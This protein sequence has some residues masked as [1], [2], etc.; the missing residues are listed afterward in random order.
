MKVNY[1]FLFVLIFT[2]F[3]LTAWAHDVDYDALVN[4]L[5][6]SD[7]YSKSASSDYALASLA[8]QD[9]LVAWLPN[10][11][12]GSTV[13]P[14]QSSGAL[15]Q[16]SQSN[17][18]D[19]SLSHSSMFN[20]TL[21][22]N[23]PWGGAV[24]FSEENTVLSSSVGVSDFLFQYQ[25]SFGLT[26]HQPLVPP[27]DGWSA[28]NQSTGALEQIA[29]SHWVMANGARVSDLL[30][31]LGNARI[32]SDE[33]QI[34]DKISDL[35]RIQKLADNELLA[36]GRLR[37]LDLRDHDSSRRQELAEKQ[38]VVSDLLEVRSKLAEAGLDDSWISSD[39]EDWIL[40]WDSQITNRTSSNSLDEQE[41]IAQQSSYRARYLAWQTYSQKQ[42]AVDFFLSCGPATSYLTSTNLFGS[43]GNYWATANNWSW[44][45]ALMISVPILPLDHLSRPK[46]E[47]D[48]GVTSLEAKYDTQ[49]AEV[50][51]QRLLIP[52]QRTELEINA[53]NLRNEWVTE[54][55]RTDVMQGLER[56]GSISATDFELQK[57]FEA[58]AHSEYLK[59]LLS[60][61]VFD[62]R[63]RL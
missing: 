13:L 44:S 35:R 27:G 9:E 53:E 20:V 31:A 54:T 5:A 16:I 55:E 1:F 23:F 38:K 49:I 52:L 26:W 2:V 50:R 24:G 60:V 47:W 3:G 40:A 7:P 59:G 57:L 30:D 19:S 29:R 8:A 6:E 41:I 48:S 28:W 62:A 18:S 63:T 12:I 15:Y 11:T 34:L 21:T 33:M 45:L 14:M 36:T 22:Q 4:R 46:Q 43:I 17:T 51:R 32:L 25:A 56:T 37:E 42:L 61:M 58:R 10:L 39:L